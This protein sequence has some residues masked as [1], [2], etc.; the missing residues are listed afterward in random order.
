MTSNLPALPQEGD[1]I[2]H[3][4]RIMDLIGSGGFGTVFRA[5]Q[6]NV[7]REVALKFLA[8]SVAKDP[9]NIERFRREAFHVSQLRHP[10]T[11]T[12]YDYGQTDDGLFYMVMELLEGEALSG[13]IQREG[14]ME[15]GRA[16]HVFIQILK[17]LS[18]AHQRG[19]VH[20]DLKPENIHLCEMF[21]ELDYVK[22]LDFGVA[23]MTSFDGGDDESE[24]KLTKAGRIF[25]TPMYMSPEQAC[26]EP[27]TTATDIY[28]LGLLLFEMMTGLPPVTG[29]NRMDVIHKQIRDEVPKLTK[30]LKGTPIGDVIR[31]ATRKAPEERY[32]DAFEITEAFYEAIAKM[33]IIPAPKGA[34]RPETFAFSAGVDLRALAQS[35]DDSVEVPEA[36]ETPSQKRRLPPPLPEKASPPPIPSAAS[37]AVE[38]S[39]DDTIREDGAALM[40][41]I[42]AATDNEEATVIAAAPTRPPEPELPLIGRQKDIER[43]VGIVGKSIKNA[44]GHIVLL[45]GESGVGKS[46]LVAGLREELMRRNVGMCVSAMRRR[47]SPLDGLREALAE[48]WWATGADRETLDAIVRADLSSLGF[49]TDE[50]DFLVDF[51]R[52]SHG[53]QRY[54]DSEESSSLFARLERALLKLAGLR[55]FALVLEDIQHAD[56]ASLSFIEYFAVTLRTQ[57]TPLAVI[58]TLRSGE[59]SLNPDLERSLRAMSTN[60]G[61]GL[62]RSRLRRLRG[63]DLSVLLDAI[64]P[65]EAR[66]KERIAWL[67]QGNPLH[68][69][70][71]VRYLEGEG[72]LRPNR[73][74]YELKEGTPREIDLPPDVMDVM[75]MR[76][77]QSL[78][79]HP[80]GEDL[81]SSLQ[82]LAALGIRVPVGLL[83]EMV[84]EARGWDS[85]R[86]GEL[87]GELGRFGLV[88][89]RT[90]R[91]APCV[92]FDN[93][94]LREALLE[95]LASSPHRPQIHRAVA[96][97]KEAFYANDPQRPMLEIAE[98]WRLA[99]DGTRYRDALFAAARAAMAGGDMR[100]A[101]DQFRE[102]M[103]LLDTRSEKGHIWGETML[104]LGSLS[105]RFGEFGLAEDTYREACESGELSGTELA[106]AHRGLAHLIFMLGRYA[107]AVHHYR[108]ALQCSTETRDPSGVAKALV[109]LSRVHT[110]RGDPNSGA[111]VR[112]RLEAM[113]PEVDPE[114]AGRVLLHLAEAAQRVG[115]MPARRAHLNAA[116][117]NFERA[118]DRQGLSDTMIELA[119]V[120]MLPAEGWP[121]RMAESGRIL[122]EA[123][124]IKRSLGD[125]HGTAEIFRYLGHL[126]QQRG[127][128]EASE[129]YLFQSLRTHEA[130]G[131]P[132]HIGAVH[133]ALGITKMWMA[134]HDQAE[135]HF[136]EAERL[137]DSVGDALAVSHAM[138]NRGTLEINR[139]DFDRALELLTRTRQAKEVLSST[140]GIYDL[141]NHLGIIALTRGLWEE[142]ERLFQF[143]LDALGENGLDEDLAVARSL[144]GLLRCVQSRVQAAALELGRAR[145]D[146]EEMSEPRI[147]AFCQGNAAFYAAFTSDDSSF[148]RLMA[149]IGTPQSLYTLHQS[150]WLEVVDRIARVAHEQS[151]NNHTRRL[152]GAASSLWRVFGDAAKAD[153]LDAL[154]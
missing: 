154:T 110:R 145:A 92:E 24:A 138:L 19:L 89:A 64:L 131:A 136:I 53:I 127:D 6:E 139:L 146:A 119:G 35:S 41:A 94:L 116:R 45:E 102:L 106:R 81:K 99:G 72:S 109:G 147:L 88:H 65:M 149:S 46:R 114:I 96:R 142:A 49:P 78:E 57:P 40:A 50:I 31:K 12:L 16:A 101:R 23:K 123:L 76:V 18:E 39:P 17:S 25:G 104:S 63:R 82:W 150:S 103:R 122:R 86:V 135:R 37:S 26:A 20:R 9:V 115:D 120:I 113:L 69:I 77:D 71:I 38:P 43:L 126:E 2:G 73:G 42:V 153:A 80:R 34:T 79:S 68:T 28:A 133:N 5:L 130:L 21:G 22:V 52:P 141:Y 107:E 29:R 47:S 108:E 70:Q 7:G 10:N 11:I 93:S 134:Q 59:L 1:L 27:I 44:S 74:R 4:F 55:P 62:T 85:A 90:H 67:S 97:A 125:R 129:Q 87:V 98:H 56:S 13:L 128:L 51:M 121:D 3:R 84:R 15:Q 151:S 152:L 91:D 112:Q 54:D 144:M 132:F 8:P 66:L 75:R 14:A 48:Y 148:E 36:S 83:E 32:Q 124:E 111:S 33:K 137:F 95:E 118:G 30:K 140:W 143:T 105:W 117:V 60:I 100:G 61:V 58:L